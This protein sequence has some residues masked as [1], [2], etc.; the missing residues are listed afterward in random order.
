MFAIF[1]DPIKFSALRNSWY[2]VRWTEIFFF[3][4]L[5]I[6]EYTS[7]TQIYII[8]HSL[9]NSFCL[10]PDEEPKL[11]RDV[12]ITVISIGKIQVLT[13]SLHPRLIRM[14]SRIGISVPNGGRVRAYETV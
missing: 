6:I 12:G 13:K 9:G 3:C 11:V 2:V 4:P 5:Y 7:I 8:V 14:K 10:S 1:V